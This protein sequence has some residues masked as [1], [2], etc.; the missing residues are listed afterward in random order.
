M[1]LRSIL[2]TLIFVNHPFGVL[3][4]QDACE[5]SSTW[6]PAAPVFPSTP[7]ERQKR[8]PGERER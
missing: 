3:G 4:T 5:D 6:Y 7:G 2:F 1:N 8:A